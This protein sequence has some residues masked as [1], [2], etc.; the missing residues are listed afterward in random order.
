MASVALEIC[1][2]RPYH[3]FRIGELIADRFGNRF[4]VEAI[5]RSIHDDSPHTYRIAPVHT[6]NAA[7][8]PRIQQLD[9]ETVHDGR[10]MRAEGG[11][12]FIPPKVPLRPC[13]DRRAHKPFGWTGRQ[14]CEACGIDMGFCVNTARWYD[15]NNTSDTIESAPE[16]APRRATHSDAAAGHVAY[17]KVTPIP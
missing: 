8:P 6:S 9:A 14:T 16:P 7:S 12:T 5:Y 10:F 17:L 4:I 1:L 11:I 3:W 13:I 2:P 15:Q